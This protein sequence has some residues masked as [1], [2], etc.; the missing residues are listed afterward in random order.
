MR[1]L[2]RDHD[3]DGVRERAFELTVDGRTVPGLLW[4]PVGATGERPLVVMAHGATR[5]KRADYLV[6]LA[7]MV[8]RRHGFAAVSIDGPG[9]GDRRDD[10]CT[11]QV[12]LFGEFLGEWAR[13]TSTDE[14]L[15]DWQSTLDV[16]ADL[17]E[18]GHGPLGFWGLSMGTIYGIPLVAAQPR[19]AAAVFGLMG[20][21]GP[22]RD[23]LALDAATVAC[24]VLF[25]QQWDDQLMARDDVL[26]LFD[27]LGSADKRLHVHPGEHAAVPAEEMAFSVAFLARHL[28]DRPSLLLGGD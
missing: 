15:A 24:P 20:L 10:G 8:V 1:W 23:R 26:A 17:D 7:R 28:G 13:P 2:D 5:H 11:D 6:S 27:A 19:V 14:V 3:D 25:L 22:T 4:T 18:V 12:Q 16:M 9:H 21:V